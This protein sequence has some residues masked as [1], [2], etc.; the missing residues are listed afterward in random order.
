VLI[1]GDLAAANRFTTASGMLARALLHGCTRLAVKLDFICG[2]MIKALEA[3]APTTSAA[4]RPAPAS[5]SAT[6]T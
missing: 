3:G 5:W 4:S 6:G 2:L 1:Y